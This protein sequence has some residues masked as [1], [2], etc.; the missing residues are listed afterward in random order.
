[1]LRSVGARGG[2]L[3][4]GIVED[5][6]HGGRSLCTK[7]A[8]LAVLH[9]GVVEVRTHDLEADGAS[10][11]GALVLREVVAPRELLAAVSALKRLVVSVGV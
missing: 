2:D 9:V 3:S 1:M 11:V 6:T 10:S 7:G 5:L 4:S 8:G